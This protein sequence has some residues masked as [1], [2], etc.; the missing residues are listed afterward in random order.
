MRRRVMVKIVPKDYA[1]SFFYVDGLPHGAETRFY[2]K[3]KS[4][5]EEIP[6][7]PYKLVLSLAPKHG[8][9]VAHEQNMDTGYPLFSLWG[10][11]MLFAT[12]CCLPREW[13]GM[14]FNRKVVLL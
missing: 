4:F 8:K 12:N 7:V 13:A 3:M 5:G 9:F 1:N 2:Q 10:S 6:T 14:R 11:N